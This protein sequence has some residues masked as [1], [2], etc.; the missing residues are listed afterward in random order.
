RAISADL[1]AVWRR[2]SRVAR[3]ESA[4]EKRA[5]RHHRA[6]GL[7]RRG[8][9]IVLIDETKAL[10]LPSLDAANHFLDRPAEARQTRGRAVR[11]VA[12]RSVAVHDEQRA[13]WIRRQVPLGDL[14]MRKIDRA[15][16]VAGVVRLR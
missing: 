16:N 11:A 4:V 1:H 3:R 10:V 6:A 7:F 5:R 2:T 9:A 15:G 12:V 13:G 14:P 8:S